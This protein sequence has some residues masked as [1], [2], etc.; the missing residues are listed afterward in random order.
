MRGWLSWRSLCRSSEGSVSTFGHT[1]RRATVL[2]SIAIAVAI[3]GRARA[4]DEVG[5]DE[6]G[7]P[8]D[9]WARAIAEA[10][11]PRWTGPRVSWT[12]PSPRPQ[13]EGPAALSA[14]RPLAV[15]AAP[16]VPAARVDR[17]LAALEQAHAWMDERGW[18]VPYPDGGRGASDGFDLYLVDGA[19]RAEEGSFELPRA[20][21]GEPDERVERSI[22]V[23]WDAPLGWGAI[24]AV[25]AFAELE[26]GVPDDALEACVTSAYVQALLAEL[27]PAE[28]PAWRRATATWIAWDLTASLGCAEAGITA[29]QEHPER[30]LVGHAPASGEAGAMLL[31]AI[32]AHHDGGS[33]DF[34][35]DLWQGV[36]QWTW[37]GEGLRAEPDLWH[38]ITH[39]LEVS[40]DPLPRLIEEVAVARWFTGA[41]AREGTASTALARAIPDEIRPHAIAEWS[42]L[43]RTALHGEPELGAHGSAYVL[44]DVR[45]APAWSV[46]NV[47]LRAEFGA[48]WS[49]VAVRLDAGGRELGRVRAPIRREPRG[50]L[51]VELREGTAAVL[52]VVTNQGGR[53]LDADE[54]DAAVR[55]FRLVLGRGEAAR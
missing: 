45:T 3:A 33:G 8:I 12:A 13:S 18:G 42:R 48:E 49:L 44:A 2:A 41:R 31:A 5:Q 39:F 20:A 28:A 46:L 9:Q 40:R 36:R 34:V 25:T 37:E 22:R 27:D 23:G 52:V 53:A 47:W 54:P 29:A 11:V 1:V 14:M 7:S 51:P 15:H 16:S 35:R 6:S 30:G 10:T 38:A 24:D 32:S 26:A 55:G 17:A 50:F 43:P 19:P 4:Q 21:E